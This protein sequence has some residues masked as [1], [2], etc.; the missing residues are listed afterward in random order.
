MGNLIVFTSV[1][2]TEYARVQATLQRIIRDIEARIAA[3]EEEK[4]RQ[5][6]E[7]ERL[8][9]ENTELQKKLETVQVE[10]NTKVHQTLQSTEFESR[11]VPENEPIVPASK[12]RQAPDLSWIQQ[13]ENIEKSG[14]ASQY[15]KHNFGQYLKSENSELERDLICLQD[16]RKQHKP[17]WT[18]LYNE[19]KKTGITPSSYV[20]SKPALTEEI[21]KDTTSHEIKEAQRKAAKLAYRK[22]KYGNKAET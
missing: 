9:Q 19:A 8:R 6:A 10:Q 18:A 3:L 1:T 17:L 4:A 16:L 7:I 14:P 21:A 11:Q 15:L 5:Q 22:K 2:N 12:I 13:W 20:S